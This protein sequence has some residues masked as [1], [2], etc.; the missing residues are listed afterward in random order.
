[1]TDPHPV[2]SSDLPFEQARIEAVAVY[3]SDGRFGE[4]F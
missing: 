2:F 1:M 4:Q 3:C